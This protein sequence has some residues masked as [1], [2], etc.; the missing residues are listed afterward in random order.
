[1]AKQGFAKDDQAKV[2]NRQQK[3]YYDCTKN[4][5]NTYRKPIRRAKKCLL[6][7]GLV[8]R[9]LRRVKVTYSTNYG[10]LIFYGEE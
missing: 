2:P 1:M 3:I 4:Y 5:V 7:I 9:N 10:T 6:N 8:L